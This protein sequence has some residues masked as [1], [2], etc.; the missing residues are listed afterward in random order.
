[1]IPR[2]G[3][4]IY[5]NE[6]NANIQFTKE[7]EEKG[8]LP[9]QDCLASCDNNELRIKVYIKPRILTDYLPDFTQSHDYK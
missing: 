2:F 9:F 1:M 8:S 7:I 4:T 6:P 3:Y 5:V